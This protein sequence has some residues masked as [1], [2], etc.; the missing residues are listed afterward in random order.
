AEERTEM[1]MSYLEELEAR[2]PPPPPT[3]TEPSRRN[4]ERKCEKEFNEYMKDKLA[5]AT[6]DFTMLLQESKMINHKSV[7]SVKE[8]EQHLRDIIDI[9]EKDKGIMSW[10]QLLKRELK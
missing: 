3:A 4:S 6:E 2:G 1:I 10:S 9:F 5:Q 7:T 8:S